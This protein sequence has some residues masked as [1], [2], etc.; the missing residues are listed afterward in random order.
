MDNK[1]LNILLNGEI[2]EKPS[3]FILFPDYFDGEFKA[4]TYSVSPNIITEFKQFETISLIVGIKNDEYQA[5]VIN[6]INY[7]NNV[8]NILNLKSVDFMNNLDDESKIKIINKTIKI[9]SPTYPIHT[10]LFILSNKNKSKNRVIL[11]SANLTNTALNT[12]IA[13]FED[14]IIFDDND[15]IFEIYNNRFELLKKHTINYIPN[16]IMNKL[17]ISNINNKSKKSLSDKSN[18]NVIAIANVDNDLINKA[19][20]IIDANELNKIEKP[21]FTPISLK[22]D[23]KEN[24]QD[25]FFAP[26]EPTIDLNDE[27]NFIKNIIDEYNNSEIKNSSFISLNSIEEEEIIIEAL[28]ELN[29]TIDTKIA[30]EILPKDILSNI[31]NESSDFLINYNNR[32]IDIQRDYKLIKDMI[33]I[34]PKK[35]LPLKFEK[36]PSKISKVIKQTLQVKMIETEKEAHLTRLNISRLDNHV[37]YEQ[38][39]GNVIQITNDNIVK[40]YSQFTNKEVIVKSLKNIDNIIRGYQNYLSKYDNEIGKKIFEVILYSFTSPFMSLI[41]KSLHTNEERQN[42]PMFYLLVE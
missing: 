42:I 13:Q 33:S 4:S 34:P 17:S 30:E 39:E 37:S 3:E 35:N 23:G 9:Y 24:E 10:K 7:Q 21:L 29:N 16:A 1:Y 40:P 41:R 25:D 18:I 38:I 22:N 11:G 12:N 14:I 26:L 15:A 31:K 27:N 8:N 36:S 28:N 20:F 6:K 32:N 2:V 5:N 19:D